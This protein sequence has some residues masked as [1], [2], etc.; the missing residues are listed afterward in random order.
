VQKT[1]NEVEAQGVGLVGGGG[2]VRANGRLR[3][4]LEEGSHRR[5]V[6]MFLPSPIMCT[7]NG[8]M[9]GAAGAFRLRL[10]E[11]TSWSAGVDPGLRLGPR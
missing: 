2:G 5:G 1:M 3:Q 10:G 4:R 11:F 8:A 6:A 7:D 9:I